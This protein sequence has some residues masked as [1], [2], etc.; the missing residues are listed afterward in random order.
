MGCTS[1]CRGDED[2]PRGELVQLFHVSDRSIAVFLCS[3]HAPLPTRG[4]D[5]KKEICRLK[6]NWFFMMMIAAL[7][8]ISYTSLSSSFHQFIT[9][10]KDSSIN[11]SVPGMEEVYSDEQRDTRSIHT[12][13]MYIARAA[14]LSTRRTKRARCQGFTITIIIKY[15]R[16]YNYLITRHPVIYCYRLL[17]VNFLQVEPGLG[18]SEAFYSWVITVFNVGAILGSLSGG[19][20]LK[21]VPYWHL[22]LGSLVF[23]T[24]GYI[25]YAVASTGWLI[26]LS[27]LL[28][29]IFIGAEM[30]L[31][32]AYFGESNSSYKTA[33]KEL[34][35]EDGKATRVKHQ[36]FALHSV[37]INIGYVFGPGM[38]AVVLCFPPSNS[39]L[40][41]YHSH[42]HFADLVLRRIYQKYIDRPGWIDFCRCMGIITVSISTGVAVIFAQF[43]IN[44]F[45]SIAWYNAVAGIAI[46]A[47]Q[48]LI[49]R[50]ESDCTKLTNCS[51]KSRTS[52]QPRKTAGPETTRLSRA[53]SLGVSLNMKYMA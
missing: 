34:G 25:L 50:G 8:A 21:W 12:Y 19:L 49:F 13:T 38:Y 30:T 6:L 22:L 27:K 3:F 5:P 20:L 15:A 17:T 44:Q 46:I 48:L 52:K 47:V 2:K 16:I 14:P 51:W 9:N 45:R 4:A 33:I 35:K 39:T 18:E 1:C 42:C 26:M 23:H 31:A 37:G 7:Y 24:L 36:L 41:Q 28:S 53:L 40:Q 32:L 10:P 29:G 43:P 11:R